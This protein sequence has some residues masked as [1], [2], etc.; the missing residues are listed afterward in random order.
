MHKNFIIIVSISCDLS[1]NYWNMPR[2][3]GEDLR[4]QIVWLR[5]FL[6][7]RFRFQI[8]ILDLNLSPKQHSYSYT[9][10]QGR[11][12]HK[13]RGILQILYLPAVGE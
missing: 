7:H 10:R 2:P 9:I 13:G 3:L 8:Q 12:S 11:Y 4:W 5:V 6:G 1:C